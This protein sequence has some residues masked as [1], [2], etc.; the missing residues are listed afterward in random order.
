MS[1]TS[2]IRDGDFDRLLIGRDLAV[3][4]DQN[5]G[6]N[7]Q[8]LTSAGEGNELFWGTNSATL[9]Q[10][11]VAGSNITFTPSGTYNGSVETTI[12]S[13]DTDTTYQGGTGITIDT[14]TNPDTINCDITQ[15][16]TNAIAGDGI[17]ITASGTERT[18]KTHI[19]EDTIDYKTGSPTKIIEVKKVP[20]KLTINEPDGTTFTYDGSVKRTLTL[21]DVGITTLNG[22]SGITITDVSATEKTITADIDNDTLGFKVVG[23]DKEI[24]VNKVPNTLTITDSAG[25]SVVYDGSTAK[26]ITINDNNTEYTGTAP[27]VVD[28]TADTIS[29]DKDDTLGTISG[30]LSVLKVPSKLQCQKGLEFGFSATDYDGSSIRVMET[31][32]DGTTINNTNNQNSQALNVLKVPNSLTI[33]DSAGTSVVYDGSTAKSIT[34][35]DTD[36][37]YQGGTGITIDTTTNPD[38]INC[39][40]TQGITKVIAGDGIVVNASGTERTIKSHI[41][42]STIVYTTGSP[43]QL[44][45]VAK[46]PNKLTAGSGI[47]FST[48]QEY[49]GSTA[50][51]ISTSATG[52]ATYVSYPHNHTFI[53]PYIST[54]PHS[55]TS[56]QLLG[57]NLSGRYLASTTAITATATSYKVE[58]SIPLNH[59]QSTIKGSSFYRLD[60]DTTGT[61]PYGTSNNQNGI[62]ILIRNNNSSPSSPNNRFFGVLTSE[63]IITGITI[64]SSVRF[65]PAFCFNPASGT[66]S[67]AS[68]Q[69]GHG[70]GQFVIT[71]TPFSNGTIAPAPATTDEDY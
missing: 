61:N 30:E 64:G 29:L 16:I 2:G 4:Q 19:D 3:G 51:T 35:N 18:I 41:D 14:S 25:A 68:I 48:G 23:S 70:M 6:T 42:Q 67:S 17:V 38:T 49:D 7:G 10:G 39:D 43:T 5:F 26:S 27:I 62:N 69:T 54:N 22:G 45:K 63:I 65:C 24:E 58:L 34:I 52:G 47:S 33:T 21:T 56:S 53:I 36:T 57:L 55:A 20:E 66:S 59:D 50:I 44:M 12:S 31:K 46:V 13:T 8:V 1:S 9:P 32:V 37:T 71:A 40:I 60:K 15:G 11:L 28:N